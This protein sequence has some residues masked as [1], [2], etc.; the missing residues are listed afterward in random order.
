L[1]VQFDVG[2]LLFAPKHVRSRGHNS[3]REQH[4][5]GQPSGGGWEAHLF[6]RLIFIGTSRAMVGVSSSFAMALMGGMALT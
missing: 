3:Q 6:R 4:N 5:L 1:A 2:E